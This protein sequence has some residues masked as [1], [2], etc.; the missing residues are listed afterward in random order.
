METRPKTPCSLVINVARGDTPILEY[1]L[2]HILD[3]HKVRF[4]EVVVVIDEQPSEGRIRQA[5]QQYPLEELYQALG[6]IRS[7]GYEFRQETVSY[8]KEDVQRV[9]SRWFG[10]SRMSYRCAGG[11]PIYAFLYGLDIARYDFRLHF[12]SDMLIYDPGPKSWVEKA[13]E[14]LE[15]VPEILFA[16]Q[17]WGIQTQAS[18]APRELPSFDL[19]YGERVSQ[20]FSSRCFLFSMNKLEKSLLPINAVKHPLAKQIVYRFQKRSPHVALEQMIS[21]TLTRQGKYRADLDMKWGL[22]LHA[23]DKSVFQDQYIGEVLKQI[24][25]GQFPNEHIGQYNLDYNCFSNL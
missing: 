3:T 5:Y 2:P 13:I 19:G 21:N 14:V 23:W 18:P 7:R 22:S 15:S 17:T 24:E 1:T 12:D 20:V 25:N 6:K 11:T 10:Q 16:N 9:F 8:R 4:A